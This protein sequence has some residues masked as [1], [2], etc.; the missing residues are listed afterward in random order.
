MELSIKPNEQR[1]LAEMMVTTS[2]SL[3]PPEPLET[4]IMIDKDASGKAHASEL[5]SG[6]NPAQ[7]IL[8]GTMQSG[9][10]LN[11]HKGAANA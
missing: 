8:P 10:V 5:V 7:T 6:E 4:S 3:C 11:M 2:C 9:K 1:T